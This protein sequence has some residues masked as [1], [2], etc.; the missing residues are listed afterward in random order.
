MFGEFRTQHA[1]NTRHPAQTIK[2][3]LFSNQHSP[4]SYF[5]CFNNRTTTF[6]QQTFI[7]VL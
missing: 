3:L 6:K 4:L 5:I 2:L 1:H 7:S